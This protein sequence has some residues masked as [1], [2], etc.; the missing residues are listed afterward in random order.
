[1]T[2]TVTDVNEP[3]GT[4]DAPT[5]SHPRQRR[6]RASWNPPVN[7]G[8]D[9]NDYDVQYRVKNT[10]N[11]NTA[12]SDH[13][14]SGA[15]NTAT[16]GELERGTIYEVKVKA[17]NPEGS[18]D[19]SPPGEGSTRANIPPVLA[20]GDTSVTRSVPENSPAGTPVGDPVS[21]TDEDIDDGGRLQYSLQG[22]GAAAFDI[23]RDTGQIQV[24]EPLDHERKSRYEVTVQVT[25]NQTG[26]DTAA[27]TIIVTDVQE[28]PGAPSP[29]SVAPGTHANTLSV[30]WTEPGNTGPAISDY[31][32][33]YRKEGAVPWK[34]WEHEGP[35][36]TNVITMLP[37]SAVHQVQIRAYNDERWSEWS[38]PGSGTTAA[39]RSPAFPPGVGDTITLTLPETLGDATDPGRDIGAPITATDPDLE[40]SVSYSLEGTDADSFTVTS[41][42]Q[43]RTK[44]DR[45]YDHEARQTYDAT[46]VAEDDEVDNTGRTTVQLVIEITDEDE[47]P[48]A[49]AQPTFTGVSRHQTTVNWT[50]PSNTGR[51]D[52]SGYQVKR[53]LKGD[54]AEGTPQDVE[55][56]LEGEPL[57]SHVAI[58][59]EDGKTY[60]FQVRGE[61]DEGWGEWSEPGEAT[62][63][64]NRIPIF[65]E[66]SSA[67]RS[68]PENSQ[69]GVD[70]GAALTAT[71]EDNDTLTY[72]IDGEN[73]GE[74]TIDYRTGRLQSGDRS[75]DHEATSSYTLTVAVNDGEG[76]R[77]AI[78]VTVNITD[79]D[80]PPDTPQAPG[81]TAVSST[82]LKASWTAPDNRGRPPIDGYVVQH[83]IDQDNSN[84]ED[85]GHSGSAI[86]ATITG[87]EPGAA[88]KVQIKA[89]N[90][91]GFSG[92]SEP[93]ASRTNQSPAVEIGFEHPEYSVPEGNAQTL[94]VT[95]S[96]DPERTVTVPV[97]VTQHGGATSDDYTLNPNIQ[98]V[99]FNTGETQ[100]TIVFNA[101]QDTEDDDDE[102]VRLTIGSGLPNRVSQGTNWQATVNIGDD[103][104]PQVTVSFE[105]NSYA[106]DE[107][108]ATTIVVTLS[109]D[110]E[111]TVTIPVA[112]THQGGATPSDYDLMP[113]VTSLTFNAGETRKTLTFTAAQDTEDDDDERVTLAFGSRL[114]D[115]ISRGTNGQAT[116]DIGDDDHPRVGV[117]FGQGSDTRISYSV[118]EGNA[119]TLTVTLS[120][121]PERT[122]SI[123]ILVTHQGGTTSDDYTLNPNIQ[124]VT[125]NTGEMQKTIIFS[126]TQDDLDDDG[127]SVI[128]T[129]GTLPDGTSPA[130]GVEITIDILDDDDP[131]VEVQFEHPEYGVFEGG[132][133]TLAV[134]LSA[135]PE[136]TVTVPLTRTNQG[137]TTGSDYS[138]VPASV[139][140]A[141]G[142]TRKTFVFAA[143]ED[144]DEEDGES[145]KLGFGTRPDRVDPGANDETTVAIRDCE[146]G[147]IWCA[148]LLFGVLTESAAGRKWLTR[149]RLDHDQFVYNGITYGIGTITLRPNRGGV[150]NP[151]AP[152]S[153]PERATLLFSLVNLSAANRQDR[154][155]MPNEDHLDWTLHISAGNDGETLEAA[156]PFNEAKFCCGRKWRSYGLDLDELNAAWEPDKLYRLRIVEDPRADRV[157]EAPGAPLYL[158]VTGSTRR[159]VGISWVRPQTRNDGAPPGVSYRIEWKMNTGSWG[160]EDDV[161][162]HVY[163]PRPGNEWLFYTIR[164]LTPGVW[165]NVRVIAVNTVGDS[166]P[167]NV[168]TRRTETDPGQAQAQQAEPEPNN[169]ATGRPV[170]NRTP[171]V[172]GTLTAD[173]SGIGDGDGL[174]NAAFTYQWLAGDAEIAGATGAKYT[175]V[176]GDE[177]KAIR[178]RVGFTDDAGNEETLTSAAT[179]AAAA[180]GLR[181]Q[182]ATLNGAA[183]VLTYNESLDEYVSL[184]LTAFTVTAAGTDRSLSQAAVSGSAV[185][186]TLSPAVAAGET[187]TVDYTRPDGPDFIRDTRGRAAD[188]FSGQKVTNQT[189]AA[190]T[191]DPF[192]ASVHDAPP[193]HD[194]STVFTFELRFSEEPKP[195][196]SYT[197]LGDHAFTVTRGE[198][199]GVRRLEPP[200]N[201]RWEIQVRPGSRD[202]VGIMLP[203]TTD[204]AEDE[205]ICT[206]DGRML[207]NRLEFNVAAPNT[208]AT[209]QPSVTG[210]PRVGETLTAATTGIED[211]DG[212]ANAVFTYRWLAGGT[213]IEGAVAASYTLTADEEGLAIQVRVSFTDDGGN[214]EAVTSAATEAVAAAWPPLTA[215]FLDTPESHD[216]SAVFT[217]ELRLSEE[218]KSDFSYTDPAGPR[219][220]GDRRRD[221]RRTPAGAPRQHP[222][223]DTGQ[224]QLGE[225]PGDS[226]A[227]HH[228]LRRRRGRLHRGRQNAV[229]PAGNHR[230]R[231]KRVTRDMENPERRQTTPMGV[232]GWT[233]T[234]QL[235]TP[236]CSQAIP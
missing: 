141:S 117:T 181:L 47:P 159:S 21:A 233:I 71:D 52:I 123:P 212:L 131:V 115:R 33:R 20:G 72:S 16:L 166:E 210:A 221:L 186:L 236:G 51:P 179:E 43:V 97:E 216:G 190:E 107:G 91:E 18:S 105:E 53:H 48:L 24:K 31:R 6:L 64:A 168:A 110:P 68:L 4:P 61:N 167:S 145:V 193:S 7:I 174:E 28:K 111:R 150:T 103:D 32:V 65:Q 144:T 5:I 191:G 40:D 87:L 109:V 156:L 98:T 208:P 153:I 101:T 188:S 13:P 14:F 215:G 10:A 83:R 76:G 195:D 75:Y 38:M 138:G 204:C 9:I 154:W 220:H 82:S 234:R 207:S 192:T 177:G 226:P 124:T 93:G 143:L 36:R 8:P 25:D 127:E 73:D 129:Y 219:L 229:Q 90:H 176:S 169:P 54:S 147:G 17:H 135:D 157:A 211:A 100:K 180:A 108:D 116:V 128:L 149:E 99:T 196:F 163:E 126:A 88:Y 187:V 224:A 121:D 213:D 139:T 70:A 42:G 102:S 113:A 142:E 80:E 184:P 230:P 152:F 132:E 84:W 170:V 134:V 223:G 63:P 203:I 85:S 173:V 202:S 27:V 81:V 114:P 146:G 119:Q 235:P 189:P 227:R 209:G 92:W 69:A 206:G 165:Y 137:G 197:T 161:S 50:A 41:T 182:S 231:T 148:T 155:T 29:P 49:P 79:V 133:V 19:W 160:T 201:T 225:Q 60:L 96:A 37:H 118:P 217:F 58:N 106:V 56:D 125:F 12:W 23:D 94:T 78:T 2:I 45:T 172:G 178:V 171:F 26:E 183:L 1:M 74:F 136:R 59:L 89:V 151:G 214:P 104:N 185:I 62:T 199:S 57:T 95:L 122:I 66:G 30:S 200:G 198:I 67:A 34:E 162:E 39:N 222:V 130:G 232:T 158:E 11:P 205:A 228:G 140:F 15:G 112:I 175:V 55:K 120:A 35:G 46:L 194:G 218:P 22:A 44:A 86:Q 77:A 164:G 3:P